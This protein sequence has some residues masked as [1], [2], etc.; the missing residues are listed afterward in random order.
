MPLMLV[1]PC[2]E[3]SRVRQ[4][5]PGEAVNAD[6]EAYARLGFTDP[7]MLAGTYRLSPAGQARLERRGSEFSLSAAAGGGTWFATAPQ[8]AASL[9]RARGGVLIGLACDRDPAQLV[10]DIRC[11]E[12][13]LG[14]GEI[15]LAW[16]PLSETQD[17]TGDPERCR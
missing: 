5:G 8:P 7:G 3:M 6:L 2:L 17:Q 1:H 11:L 4:I 15:L 12:Y 14:N 13:A 9:V 16:A 10:T